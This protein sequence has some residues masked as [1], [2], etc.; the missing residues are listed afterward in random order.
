MVAV[1]TK[2]VIKSGLSSENSFQFRKDSA[3]LG[4]PRDAFGKLGR[5]SEH[6]D[7]RG[8]VNEHV[9]MSAPVSSMQGGRPTSTA[10]MAGTMH[11]G[12]AP[13]PSGPSS[14]GGPSSGA[15]QGRMGSSGPGVSSPSTGSVHTSSPSS[16]PS[17]SGGSRGH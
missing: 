2:P 13:P 10:V 15:M 11:R 14:F 17:S 7:S 12:A 1:N 16:A 4:V 6:V 3:G 5:L 8:M 9:Y